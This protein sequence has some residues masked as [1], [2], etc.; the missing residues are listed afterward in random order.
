M[1]SKG[2]MDTSLE[3]IRANQGHSIAIDLGLIPREPPAELWHGT[4]TRFPPIVKR[5]PSMCFA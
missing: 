3:R 2:I 4:V 1:I 5:A